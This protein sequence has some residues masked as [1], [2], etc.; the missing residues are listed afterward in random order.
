MHLSTDDLVEALRGEGFR[1]TAARRAI[2]SVLAD[3]HEEHLSATDIQSRAAD[4]SAIEIDQSTVY[5]TLDVFE[6]LGWLHHVHLGHGPGIIHL[7]DKTDHHHLVCESCGKSVDVELDEL[8]AV[9][10]T[11]SKR[12]GFAPTSLHF[13]LVGTCNACAQLSED[14]S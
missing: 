4:L 12:Y 10:G 1:I 14:P 9:F 11:L 2:C 7:T 5:R 6:Q 13:A 8:E 3:S